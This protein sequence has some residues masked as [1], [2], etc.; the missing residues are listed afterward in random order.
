MDGVLR[1]SRVRD[2]WWENRFSGSWSMSQLWLALSG[3][4]SLKL[5]VGTR[6]RRGQKGIETRTDGN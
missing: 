1:N 4:R 2:R 3:G 6:G 5:S